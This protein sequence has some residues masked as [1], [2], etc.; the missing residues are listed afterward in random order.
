MANVIRLFG[1]AD[2]FNIEFSRKGEHWEVEI[3][4]DLVDGVY[5]VQLTAV[6]ELGEIAY[7]VGEL[8][9]CNGTCCVKIK[10]KLAKNF[11]SVEDFCLEIIPSNAIKINAYKY[12]STF[13]ENLNILFK[14]IRK[15]CKNV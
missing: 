10:K 11:L 4:A 9:M 12:E 14:S 2:N 1:K 3:P 7:W 8:Y 6:D 15:E 13:T 5:A